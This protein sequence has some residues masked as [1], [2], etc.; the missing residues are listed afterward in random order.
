[1]SNKGKKANNLIKEKSPYL[2]Q[3]AYNPINWYPWGDEAFKKAR[4]EDKPIFLSIGYP[5]CHWCHVMERESFEDLEVAKFF[6]DNF[7]SIK[8]DREERPDIDSVYMTVCQAMTGSGGWPLTIFMTPEQKPFYAGTYFPKR[9]RFNNLGILD[10]GEYVIEKWRNE[11]DEILNATKSLE[12]HLEKVFHVEMSDKELNEEVFHDTYKQLKRFY[13]EVY[14]G[15]TNAPKFPTPHKIIYLLK[16]YKMFNEEKALDMATKT[17][18]SMYKG[19]IF[20]HI[21]FGFSRYSTDDKWLVPH[22]EKMLYDNALLVLAYLEGY[23]VTKR[24]EYKDIALK[25]FDYVFRELLDKDGGFYCAEDADSEG[26]EGKYYVFSPLEIID[27][28]G[29]ED[30]KYFNEYFSITDKGNFEGKN[31]PNMLSLKEPFKEN[32]KIDT[33]RKKVLD[34]REKRVK[35][36]KDDK[37]LT[38]LN[39]LMLA[40][41]GKAYKITSDKKYLEQGDKCINF[42]YTKMF[43]EKGRLLARYR[44]GESKY[45]GFLD[46]YSFLTFGLI[47]M[48]E[49]TY[50]ESYLEK[51]V[52]LTKD[53]IEIF[54]DKENGGFYL[55]GKDGEKLI[56]NPKDIYDGAIPSGNAV[57]TYNLMYLSK[58][59]LDSE[60]ENIYKKQKEFIMGRINDY[61]INYSFFITSALL[62]FR[63]SKDLVVV[64]KDKEDLEDLKAI[65]RGEDTIYTIIKTKDNEEILNEIAP[66]IKDYKLKDHKTTFYLCEGFTCKEPFNNISELKK[67]L[68]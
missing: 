29:E 15:F 13:D 18:D 67:Y 58:L 51:A 5:T 64:A 43:N 17:L 16:Y 41:L 55:Y 34:Y 38:S 12:T 4:Q 6:N 45:L 54:F 14:G 56:A 30:G 2:L 46:D 57:A 59:T 25:I 66:F 22:F 32:L 33:L 37:I 62:D 27:I 19:G 21:G 31:I 20:D 49:G 9:S 61:Y 63:E 8:V 65:L 60:L 44:D 3:H 36:H 26:V 47:N 68:K 7:V 40:A 52:N 53:M 28:L 35:P 23:E 11:K 24:A 48:Y 39:G 10:L 42:L 50:N 1:M